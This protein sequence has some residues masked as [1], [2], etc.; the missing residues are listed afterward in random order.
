MQVPDE[1][2]VPRHRPGGNGISPSMKSQAEWLRHDEVGRLP[3]VSSARQQGDARDSRRRSA[4][5][6]AR[7]RR[8]SG[9]SSRARPARNM[10][11]RHERSSGT[12]RALAMFA[13]WTDRI[14]GGRTAAGAAAAAGHRAQRRHHRVGL[15]R[16]EGVPARRG[17]DRP[18]Q[19]DGERQRPDLRLARA[20]RRLPAGARSGAATRSARC[21]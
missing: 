21:R 5:S 8:G 2:R 4:R 11:R 3:G 13:D 19:S 9:A 17:L 18:A 10:M 15:G 14:A 20:E 16:S 6:L 7:R 12:E 1:E